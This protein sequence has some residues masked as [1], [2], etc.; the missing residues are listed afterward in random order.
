[1]L[2]YT[3]RKINFVIHFSSYFGC[4]CW[5]Q[6]FARWSLWE[7]AGVA[8]CQRADCNSPITG[9]RYTHQPNLCSG[10][11]F[12]G[13]ASAAQRKG[14][15]RTKRVF[16]KQREH[17]CQEEEKNKDEVLHGGGDSHT[18][19]CGEDYGNTGGCFLKEQWL[20]EKSAPWTKGKN[21]TG[22]ENQT[23]T[24]IL[25]C[26]LNVSQFLSNLKILE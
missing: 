16:N 8:L 25:P 7:E 2:D 13:T 20:V 26:T 24:F 18:V 9:H 5:H 23:E 15:H 21:V 6:G 14:G 19:A 11:A 22:K 3:F 1:M 10:K 4:L 17:Q 12:L